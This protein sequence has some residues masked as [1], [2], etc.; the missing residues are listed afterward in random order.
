MMCKR[1]ERRASS[2]THRL[3]LL[4]FAS[5]KLKADR[6]FLDIFVV[7]DVVR[8]AEGV[9]NCDDRV[10]MILLLMQPSSRPEA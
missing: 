6:A 5:K 3:A 2:W 8:V 7:S 10:E 4:A 1:R 9:L